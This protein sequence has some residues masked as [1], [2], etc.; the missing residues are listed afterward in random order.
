M[1]DVVLSH[2]AK[3][4]LLPT[5]DIG[6]TNSATQDATYWGAWHSV[7]GYS[8]IYAKVMIGTW[9]ATD[10]LDTCKLQQ[11]TSSAGADVKDL[12]TSGS[13]Y[14]YDTDAPIDAAT[15]TVVLEARAEDLDVAGGFKYVRVYAAETGNTGTDNIDG[16]LILYGAVDKTAQKEGAASSGVTVYVTPNS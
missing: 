4:V 6:G 12:T 10:D 2:D 5:A 7:A 14:N 1:A 15:N 8:K 13:G 3:V 16:V 9:N 11:A